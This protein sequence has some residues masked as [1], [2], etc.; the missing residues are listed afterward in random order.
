MGL[1]I[2]EECFLDVFADIRWGDRLYTPENMEVPCGH[3]ASVTKCDTSDRWQWWPYFSLYFH[4][5]SY[6]TLVWDWF[7]LHSA[8]ALHSGSIGEVGYAWIRPDKHLSTESR[9]I[10]SRRPFNLWV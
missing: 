5:T 9:I 3:F 1:V 4:H 10:I 7:V 2:L 6:G 8:S